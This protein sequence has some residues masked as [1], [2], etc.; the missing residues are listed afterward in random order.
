MIRHFIL[1]LLLITLSG[2]ADSAEESLP[3]VAAPAEMEAPPAVVA[4]QDVVLRFLRTSANQMVPPEG[5]AWQAGL[6]NAPAGF[7]VYRFTT[8]DAMM[9]VSYPRDGQADTVYHVTV[10]DLS[11]GFCWQANV[12]AGGEVLQTGREAEM[13]PE[14]QNAAAAYCQQQGFTYAIRADEDGRRCG[15]C[16]FDDGTSCNAWSYLQDQCEPGWQ[17]GEE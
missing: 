11:T 8:G 7:D 5:A 15:F 6:G 10:S 2:C 13:L 17:Q 1:L 3:T 9:T 14:L 16:D 12:S 4:A